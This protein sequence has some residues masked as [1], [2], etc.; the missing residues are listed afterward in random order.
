MKILI[1]I[2]IQQIVNKINCHVRH[3][4]PVFN[5]YPPIR[6]LNW[7]FF[8]IDRRGVCANS[9]PKNFMPF[10]VVQPRR[11]KVSV[12]GWGIG[13]KKQGARKSETSGQSDWEIDWKSSE[14]S[15]NGDFDWIICEGST[16]VRFFLKFEDTQPHKLSSETVW[17]ENVELEEWHPDTREMF[18]SRHLIAT[19]TALGAVAIADIVS[20]N[21]H[22]PPIPKKPPKIIWVTPFTYPRCLGAT[23]KVDI[24]APP[25]RNAVLRD[26][27]TCMLRRVHH[28]RYLRRQIMC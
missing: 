22:K 14:K 3:W 26:V 1:K 13:T 19:S 5:K 28:E 15:L 20:T 12:E 4:T 16:R 25:R 24:D 27:A 7:T 8:F 6:R 9:W 21:R 11:R 23:V 10:C 18:P 2:K 17:T